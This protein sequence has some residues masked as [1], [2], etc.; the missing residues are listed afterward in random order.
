MQQYAAGAGS[1]AVLPPSSDSVP[2][3]RERTRR[4]WPV[5]VAVAVAVLVVLALFATGVLSTSHGSNVNPDV[6]Y[7]KASALAGSAVR[8]VPGGPWT[9]LVAVGI[10]SMAG[11]TLVLENLSAANCSLALVG[12]ASPTLRVPTDDQ[13]SSGASPWWILLY[14]NRT[15]P[16]ILLVDVVNGTAQPLAT[17]TGL[18][19]TSVA[20]LDAVSSNVVDSPGPASELWS[21]GG[22]SFA[23]DHSQIPLNLIMALTGGGSISNSTGSSFVFGATWLLV[24]SP[25]GSPYGGSPPGKQPVFLAPFNAT[26]GLLEGAPLFP[27]TT[28]TTCTNL[29]SLVPSGSSQALDLHGSV[30]GSPPDGVST[31]VRAGCANAGISGAYGSRSLGAIALRG[32]RSADG[33]SHWTGPE[34]SSNG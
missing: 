26:S 30:A 20:G 2:P 22:S 29:T 27:D 19:A 1:A 14:V 7:S 28:T 11:F 21:V 8:S 12:S 3:R 17:G 16:R 5:L 24:L 25:C 33:S 34:G 4:L 13:F 23:S 10:D 18:C 32:L 6:T 31:G 15:A 9:L